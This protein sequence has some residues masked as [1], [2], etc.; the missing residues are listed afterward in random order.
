MP[1]VSRFFGIIIS[2][3]FNDHNPPHFHAKYGEDEAV[4]SINDLSILEGSISARAFA[5]I[6]EWVNLHK[7]ELEKN[8]ELVKNFQAPKQIEPLT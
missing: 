2:F 3:Y 4:I 7:N 8:W 1:Q 5:L 6:S